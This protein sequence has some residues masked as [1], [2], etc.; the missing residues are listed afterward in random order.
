MQFEA[1]SLKSLVK[2]IDHELPHSTINKDGFTQISETYIQYSV[3]SYTL[4]NGQVRC[5][6]FLEID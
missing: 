5:T 1:G 3:R 4:A 6:T 2:E